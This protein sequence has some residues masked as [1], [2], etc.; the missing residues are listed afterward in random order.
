MLYELESMGIIIDTENIQ[1][2][3]QEVGCNFIG[4]ME[5][6]L[7]FKTT[8]NGQIVLKGIGNLIQKDFIYLVKRML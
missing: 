5:Y 1:L 6:Y 4:H 8:D 3:R 7:K 2:I